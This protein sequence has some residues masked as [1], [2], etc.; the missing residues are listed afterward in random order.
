[1]KRYLIFLC[2]SS[3]PVMPPASAEEIGR[4]AASAYCRDES[5]QVRSPPARPAERAE[6]ARAPR[7]MIKT[8]APVEGADCYFYLSEVALGPPRPCSSP[9]V[10]GKDKQ[11]AGTLGSQSCA[12]R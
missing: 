10:G 11:I 6:A 12:D 1:M 2:I 9:N 4:L 7:A 8:A 5:G 3:F